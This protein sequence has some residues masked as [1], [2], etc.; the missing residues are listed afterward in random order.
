MMKKYLPFVLSGLA[1]LVLWYILT[2]NL[3]G[4]D[5]G[6]GVRQAP[7]S[8]L[9]IVTNLVPDTNNTRDAGAFGNAF[10]ELYV[11]STAYLGGVSTTGGVYPTTNNTLDLG[12]YQ[13]SWDDVFVSGTIATP[14]LTFVDTD[15]F[16][17]MAFVKPEFNGSLQLGNFGNAFSSIFAS[18][19]LYTT[20]GNFEVGGIGPSG[21]FPNSPAVYSI[22]LY[23]RPWSDYY[24]SG[25]IFATNLDTSAT[26]TLRAGLV[27]ASSTGSFF[28]ASTS[29]NVYMQQL[30]RENA[31][32][33]DTDAICRD[34]ITG[35]ILVNPGDTCLLSTR[36]AKDNIEDLQINGLDFVRSLRPRQYTTKVANERRVGLIAEE[37]AEID[38]RLVERN[39]DGSLQTV[40]YQELVAPLI[41]AIQELEA[42]VKELE[43]KK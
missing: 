43:K 12:S 24:S 40:R 7:F 25:T 2:P 20:V 11:S 37:V 32:S 3:F 10:N 4:L 6:R 42:K 38:E 27:V 30:Q 36:R 35:Q 5:N 31:A 16:T 41:L 28:S 17:L 1:G 9:S 33:N 34:V 22:G 8:G 14:D 18:G 23:D 15:P 26:A 13:R 29:G 19:S 21:I 39:S